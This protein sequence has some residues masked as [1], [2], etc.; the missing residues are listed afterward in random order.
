MVTTTSIPYRYGPKL[1]KDV[2]RVAEPA[3]AGTFCQEP[4]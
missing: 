2:S 3:E 4:V 1:V